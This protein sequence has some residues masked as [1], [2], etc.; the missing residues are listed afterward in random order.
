MDYGQQMSI[1]GASSDVPRVKKSQ[2]FP[3]SKALPVSL[4]SP[5]SQ[6]NSV[7]S[8]CKTECV[9]PIETGL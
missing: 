8:S 1:P 5:L 2:V 9:S 4:N 3:L 7:I 6:C